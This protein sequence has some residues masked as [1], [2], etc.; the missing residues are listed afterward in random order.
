[1]N[2]IHKYQLRLLAGKPLTILVK[3]CLLLL[4]C[5]LQ[6][7][8]ICVWFEINEVAP[9]EE[10]TFIGYNTGQ[11]LKLT[12]GLHSHIET[13]LFDNGNYVFHVYRIT[14]VDQLTY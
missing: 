13:I 7:D 3:N 2:T 14:P 12:L 4:K 6:G 11:E 5:A 9:D 10:Y 8:V 1:M